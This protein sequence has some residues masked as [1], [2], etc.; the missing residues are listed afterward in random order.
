M[1]RR[2]SQG[3]EWQYVVFWELQLVGIFVD[4]IADEAGGVG[5]GQIR[6]VVLEFELLQG[7]RST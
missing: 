1:E 4:V 2:T 5:R 3:K 6:N 7:A